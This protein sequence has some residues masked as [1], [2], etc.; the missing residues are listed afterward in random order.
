MYDYQPDLLPLFEELGLYL[1][2]SDVA[3]LR[4]MADIQQRITRFQQGFG[5]S[6]APG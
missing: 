5:E 2:I 6:P 4:D 3:V 1:S